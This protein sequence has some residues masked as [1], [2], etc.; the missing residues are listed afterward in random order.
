MASWADLVSTTL[1]SIPKQVVLVTGEISSL[2]WDKVREAL[3]GYSTYTRVLTPKDLSYALTSLGTSSAYLLVNPSPLLIEAASDLIR[4]GCTDSM[5]VLIDDVPKDADAIDYLKK[6]AQQC[7]AYYTISAPK[8]DQAKSTMASVFQMRWGVT[9][10]SAFRVCTMLDF[11]PGRLY[12]FDQL[13]LRAT[14]GKVL[15]SS[16]TNAVLTQLLGADSPNTVVAHILEGRPVEMNY[17]AEF[18]SQILRVMLSVILDAKVVRGAMDRGCTNVS[19]IT[20]DTGLSQFQ[21]VRAF[22]AAEAWSVRALIHREKMLR[23]GLENVT[24]P[25]VLSIV[26][27]LFQGE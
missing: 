27:L 3:H 18:S 13:F 10:D 26:S 21:V 2:V 5:Y 7:K 1:P 22:G 17:S 9:R 23:F 15:P 16:E 4:G 24:Q 19:T 11:S 20:K 6:K 8:T 12:Q 14:G 25:D